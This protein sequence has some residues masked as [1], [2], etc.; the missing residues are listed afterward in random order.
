MD[1]Q[2]G[3]PAEQPAADQPAEP[4][5]K[6]RRL[7]K[8][9]RPWGKTGPRKKSKGNVANL[10]PHKK[11]DIIPTAWKKGE[12]GVNLQLRWRRVNDAVKREFFTKAQ[13]LELWRLGWDWI[14]DPTIPWSERVGLLKHYQD[15]A[16]GKPSSKVDVEV[17]NDPQGTLEERTNRAMIAAGLIAAQATLAAQQQVKVTTLESAEGEVVEASDKTEE[18]Q[19]ETPQAAPLRQLEDSTGNGGSGV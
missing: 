11:G 17:N 19:A 6:K 10:K 18:A 2:N 15:H 13:V 9:G 7:R 14:N 4:V 8:D 16:N 12:C 3:Q 5:K 1:E